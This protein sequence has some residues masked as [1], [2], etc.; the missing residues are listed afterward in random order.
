M[1][2]VIL[3]IDGFLG[4][5][6]EPWKIPKMSELP[7]ITL[8]I[9]KDASAFKPYLRD[10]ETLS[11]NGHSPEWKDLSTTLADLRKIFPAL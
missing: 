4:N 2:P 11:R 7:P 9:A 8:R 1:L 5:G 10:Q 6:T 3:L